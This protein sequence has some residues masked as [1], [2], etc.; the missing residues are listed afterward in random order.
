MFAVRPWIGKLSNRPYAR[1]SDFAAH[2][3]FRTPIL[4]ASITSSRYVLATA[5]AAECRSLAWQTVADGDTDIRNQSS[6]RTRRFICRNIKFAA[7]HSSRHRFSSR[8]L[9]LVRARRSAQCHAGSRG[10]CYPRATRPAPKRGARFR[11]IFNPPMAATW[12]F[13]F[14]AATLRARKNWRRHVS[15]RLVRTTK[16]VTARARKQCRLTG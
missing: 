1:A 16:A 14:T 7:Q 9:K 6:S 5:D 8:W 4:L 2:L 11:S 13:Q 10:I 12:H 3:S 15:G